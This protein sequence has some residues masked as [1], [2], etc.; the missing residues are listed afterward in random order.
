VSVPAGSSALDNTLGNYANNQLNE[1]AG[2][3]NAGNSPAVQAAL[4]MAIAA[5]RNGYDALIP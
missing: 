1:L 4:D 5:L 2:A 3:A